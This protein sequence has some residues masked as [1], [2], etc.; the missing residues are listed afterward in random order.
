MVSQ[1]VLNLPLTLKTAFLQ[2]E[3]KLFL[4]DP[5]SY[6]YFNYFSSFLDSYPQNCPGYHTPPSPSSDLHFN[7]S[8][9]SSEDAYSTPLRK[10]TPQLVFSDMYEELNLKR[11]LEKLTPHKVPLS[12]EHSN[13]CQIKSNKNPKGITPFSTRSSENDKIFVDNLYHRR[14][15]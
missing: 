7:K 12:N 10:K 1:S 8:I 6:V 13:F 2:N 3:R 4:K 14:D 9:S 11:E 5:V 15:N